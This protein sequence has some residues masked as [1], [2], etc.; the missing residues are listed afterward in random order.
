MKAVVAKFWT[1]NLYAGKPIKLFYQITC[2]SRTLH[3]VEAE[4]CIRHTMGKLKNCI[5]S[6]AMK[7]ILS[8]LHTYWGSH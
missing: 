1:L 8:K 2:G 5:S 7:P 3:A 6:E 4:T